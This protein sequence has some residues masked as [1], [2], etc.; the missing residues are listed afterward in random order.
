MGRGDP[1]C[2]GMGSVRTPVPPTHVMAAVSARKAWAVT[3]H[4]MFFTATFCPMYSPCRTSGGGC[5]ASGVG[6]P[7]RAPGQQ[8]WHPG[9]SPGDALCGPLA[10]EP[11]F[12]LLTSELA[13]PDAL[14]QC[15]LL[16]VEQPAG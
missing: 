8:G 12:H 14:S 15:E 11:R 2:R 16:Q 10:E 1:Q 6:T 9:R 7:H 4:L 13:L 3:S 5:K